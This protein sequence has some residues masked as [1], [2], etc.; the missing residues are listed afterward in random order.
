MLLQKLITALTITAISAVSFIIQN[1]CAEGNFVKAL[2]LHENLMPLHIALFLEPSPAG[3][4]HAA[5]LLGLCESETRLPG[6]PLT[7]ATADRVEAAL[8]DVGLLG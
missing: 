3:A 5:S 7:K 2:D 8:K 1:A 4:K 6:V